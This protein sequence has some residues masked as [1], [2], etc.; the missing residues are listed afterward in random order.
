MAEIKRIQLRGISRAP[1]DRLTEDGGVAE[2]L[3]IQ[4]D[5]TEAAPI[6]QP[7]DVSE[8]W[9]FPNNIKVDYESTLNID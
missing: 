9:G 3:N 2:S 8:K 5:N 7:K 4:I 1:S 6:V